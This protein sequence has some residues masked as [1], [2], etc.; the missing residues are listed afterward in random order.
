MLVRGDTNQ[1][2]GRTAATD[3]FN[4]AKKYKNTNERMPKYL[5]LLALT[6]G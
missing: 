3:F 1:G 5:C 6:Y 4:K 2:L